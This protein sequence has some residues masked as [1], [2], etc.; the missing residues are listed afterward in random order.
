MFCI[1]HR[2]T[3]FPTVYNA[4]KSHYVITNTNDS[5]ELSGLHDELSGL[6]DELSGLHDELSGLY[7]AR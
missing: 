6:H 3:D 7:C 4:L 1:L 2:R 5:D